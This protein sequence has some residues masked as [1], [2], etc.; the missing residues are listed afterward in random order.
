MRERVRENAKKGEREKERESV[1]PER[2]YK[3]L[4]EGQDGEEEKGG[5]VRCKDEGVSVGAGQGEL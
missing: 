4:E 1:Q 3:G 5:W 2:Q